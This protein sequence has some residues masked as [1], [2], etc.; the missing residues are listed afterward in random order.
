MVR[1]SS[2][3]WRVGKLSDVAEAQQQNECDDRSNHH[4][5]HALA[6]LRLDVLIQSRRMK[7]TVFAGKGAVS[8][9]LYSTGRLIIQ[10]TDNIKEIE[11]LTEE[12]VLEEMAT[13]K[14]DA[15][16]MLVDLLGSLFDEAETMQIKYKQERAA[17]RKQRLAQTIQRTED[18][19][20]DEQG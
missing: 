5:R 12:S 4:D 7:V 1:D 16:R 8:Y 9:T 2:R 6:V 19:S 13:G 11:P 20:S 18:S 10:Y 14:E 17:I 15:G 3:Y